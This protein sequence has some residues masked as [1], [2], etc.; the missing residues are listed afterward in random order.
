[1]TLSDLKKYYSED[2]QLQSLE[3]ALGL[4]G[5]KVN[6]KG[7]IGSSSAF[8]AS[9]I[10]AK[11]QGTH[12]FI[13]P[14]KEA[15]VYFMNDLETL[16]KE[17]FKI[18]FYPRSAR[19]PYQEEKTENANISMRAE[20]L[21]E[22]NK[23]KDTLAI[24]T[25]PEALAEHVVT[26]KMLSKNT[27]DLNVGDSFDMEF[28]DEAFQ[29]FGF[30]KVDYVFQPG[31]Y[32]VRGGIV[33]V[34][35]YSFDY[36]YRLEFFGDE[37]DSIRKFDPATQLS[38][39]K[40]T[41]ATI[42]PDLKNK[43]LQES[44]ESFFEF[45][46]PQSIIW[47]KDLELNANRVD[48]ELEKAEEIYERLT[49]ETK[50]LSPEELYIGKNSFITQVTR[51]TTV[52]FG[53][54]VYFKDG[55][56]FTFR[57]SP[58]PAFAKNFDLLG[59]N[60]KSNEKHGYKNIILSGQPKQIERLYKIFDDKDHEINF[61]PIV[62]ELSEGFIDQERKLLCYTDHQL[63]ERYHRFRLKEGFKKNS[64][65][66]TL[67][68]L[69]QLVP[70]DFVVHIDHGI[71]RFSGLE[72]LNINGKE[73]EAIRLVYRDNDIL[74]VSIH[75]LH[76]I[77]KFV[78]K[79]GTP[80]KINKLGSQTWSKLKKKTKSKIKE[81]AYDLL[82]L[83]AKRKHSKG[84]A[85]T[86]DSYLQTELEASFI[87]EDTPDQ[88]SA[89]LAIK[90]DMESENPMDR[91]I[92]GDVGF[93]KT[94]VAIRAA[95][96]AVA[97]NKQVAVLVPTTILSLQHYKS[98][99][100]R[101]KEFPCT[102]DYINRFKSAKQKTDTFKRLEEGKIDILIGTHAIVGKRVKFK[103]LGLMIIDEEQK[104]G[105]AV[106][107]K[108]KTMKANVDT[109]TLTATPI[110]RTLQFSMMGARDMSIIKTPPPN[111]YPIET[112][113]TTLNES[114]IRDA[115]NYEIARGGQVFF[116]HN[117]I[118]NI[119]EVA[120]M[121]QRLCPDVRIGIGH[122]QMDGKKLEKIM[123][124]FIDGLYDVLIATTIIE[125]GIDIPNANTI[126]INHAHNFG[127][128]DLHQ[129]RGRVGRTNKKAFCYLLSHPLH[130]LPTE[131]RKRLQALEQFSDLGSGLNIAMRDLDIRGAGNLL[132]GEQSGF[133]ADIGFETY[134]KILNEA[135]A[136]LKE[137]QFK[138]MYD[139]EQVKNQDFIKETQIET[140]F[141]ILLPDEYVDGIAERISLYRELD[142]LETE[143][144]LQA[145]ISR[146]I[147]R[148]GPLPQ[149]T[150]DLIETIRMRWIAKEV[151][152]EKIILKN[153]VMIGSFISKEDSPYFQS[154]K[155]TKV[156][157]Y[158][159]KHHKTGKMYQKNKGLRMSF[160]DV[161]SIEKA[162][163]I[164]QDI[165]AEN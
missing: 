111:R 116:V 132:G 13:L 135:V 105:V 115:V 29:E 35:S 87:Y 48:R 112:I 15:A 58:Q 46:A 70:G 126:I 36:P 147:D 103:D 69:T 3:A 104:F 67:K 24:V 149:Q 62:A 140:D 106:K 66:L 41:R 33:D 63:F 37:I 19:V 122:G 47:H 118:E 133:M 68:E 107:D 125:S 83:Y 129:L 7:T 121:V 55:K 144:E 40:M 165:Q 30:E 27:F 151:G 11:T 18:L 101:L 45:I 159:K 150:L 9:A 95:F 8:I 85:F 128:S 92:C 161:T 137:E 49:G 119:K 141:E 14:D 157:N 86:P 109:L 44:R 61:T 93:G 145:F 6:L 57:M 100:E 43:F 4:P 10:V 39:N 26:K 110:P 90:Q 51:F 88:E 75:S 102:V 25:F 81:L 77:S 32:A 134:Q 91:L 142:N 163:K 71:G 99:K 152:F 131:S 98:F 65:A 114:T 153:N 54:R 42:V 80:P 1:M 74:Y 160:Q 60:L 72:K 148:F 28:I 158:L 117:R 138:E 146:M 16:G 38:V 53:Q 20:V 78:G 59:K 56:Q 113:L 79:D 89:T 154:D 82:K 96:K 127:L 50:R 143:E 12:V 31:Q 5:S 21:N 52:E 162:I 22:I 94:E 34:F 76:R 156:L 84:F 97:D 120:G 130:L 73:Q 64:E 17:D 2:P 136:E 155:F 108:L 124:D 23:K 139:E 123:T 164:L